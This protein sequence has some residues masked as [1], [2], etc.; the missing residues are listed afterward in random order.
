MAFALDAIVGGITYSL[1]DGTLCNYVGQDGLGMAPT[2][3]MRERG[4]QQAGVT[5]LGYLL[6]ERYFRVFLDVHGTSAADICNRRNTLLRI[7]QGAADPVT[8]RFLRSNGDYRSIDADYIDGLS[9]SSA[10]RIGFVERAA[11]LMAAADPTFYDPAMV[12]VDF[13]L[14]P[15]GAWAIPWVIPWPIGAAAIDDIQAIVYSG[16][17]P[18]HPIIYI[19]GPITNP[20]IENETTGERLDF[21]G[22]SIVVGDTYTIDC[23][24]GY[25]T[26]TDNAGN[27]KIAELTEDSDLSTFHLAAAVDG[28]DSLTNTIRVTG[29]NVTA[30][31]NITMTYYQRY[32]GI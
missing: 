15:G 22:Y 19:G 32:V 10:A 4:P 23:R 27:S 5:D 28:T 9:F 31:T 1:S 7:L 25:K 3:R 20:V 13:A 11:V 30:V 24:Y 18:S 16:S 8:L 6:D 26:V 14:A 2:H 17:A 12:G 29:I 21:T